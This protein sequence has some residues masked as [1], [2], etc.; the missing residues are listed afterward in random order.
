MDDHALQFVLIILLLGPRIFLLS[1]VVLFLGVVFFL[2]AVVV[3]LLC[4]LEALL[5]VREE[6]NGVKELAVGVELELLHGV[7][8]ELEPLQSEYHYGRE[9][10]ETN[11][12]QSL[13]L[14]V[15][16]LTEV[17]VLPLHDLPF[18]QL[19]QGLVNRL[20]VFN[21][22]PN[23]QEVFDPLTGVGTLLTDDQVRQLPS[24]HV[25]DDL[26]ATHCL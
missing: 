9:L 24:K 6:V 16:F 11:P 4:V 22:Q 25:V 3:L 14:L 21:L 19:V 2:L 18:N 26:L 12:L 1:L 20:L 7:V 13:D 17:S 15:T 5:G 23:R 10:L 8:V